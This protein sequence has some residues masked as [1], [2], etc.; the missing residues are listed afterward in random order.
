MI[1]LFQ[2]QF[3][4]KNIVS[5]KKTERG[6]ININRCFIDDFFAIKYEE[7]TRYAVKTLFVESWEAN[8]SGFPIF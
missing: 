1:V 2:T 6:K 7:R 8:Y 3:H 4:L 5:F